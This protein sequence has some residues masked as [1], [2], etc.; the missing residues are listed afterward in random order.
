M[1]IG[2]NRYLK[3]PWNFYLC[4]MKIFCDTNLCNRAQFTQIELKQYVML[5]NQGSTYEKN[6]EGR[7]GWLTRQVGEVGNR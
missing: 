3:I 7:E 5:D 4:V 1:R 6:M 2:E